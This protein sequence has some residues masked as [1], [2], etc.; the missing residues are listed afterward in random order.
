MKI[1]VLP[2]TAVLA[3]CSAGAAVP[4]PELRKPDTELMMPPLRLLA[5]PVG[6]KGDA[7]LWEAYGQCRVAHANSENLRSGL[8]AYVRAIHGS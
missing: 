1:V 2:L 6:A 4:T 3:G 8:V 5:L 7:A